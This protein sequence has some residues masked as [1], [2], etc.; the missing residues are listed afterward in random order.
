VP[1]AF[2]ACSAWPEWRDAV[3]FGD[4][5]YVGGCPRGQAGSLG[6]ADVAFK[7]RDHKLFKLF[8][9]LFDLAFCLFKTFCR[10]FERF[11]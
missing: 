11:A 2:S 1:S 3:C 6:G 8:P 7:T 4:L 5:S 10:G 9:D